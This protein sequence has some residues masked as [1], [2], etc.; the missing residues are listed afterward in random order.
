MIPTLRHVRVLLL[1]AFGLVATTSSAQSVGPVEGLNACESGDDRKALALLQPFEGRGD[2]RVDGCLAALF[3]QGIVVR[4]DTARAF[5]LASSAAAKDDA[6][7]HNVLGL[8]FKRGE[9]PNSTTP[10]PKAAFEH[11]Q[12]SADLG[13]ANGLTNLGECYWQGRGVKADALRAIAL[14]M[15]AAAKGRAVAMHHL[16]TI[17]LEGAPTVAVNR[18]QAELW[19]VRA[20]TQGKGLNDETRLEDSRDLGK[21]LLERGAVADALPYLQYA[22][23]RND[24]TA[25]ALLKKASQPSATTPVK[26]GQTGYERLDRTCV[27]QADAVRLQAALTDLY[28]GRFAPGAAKLAAAVRQAPPCLRL[29][30]LTVLAGQAKLVDKVGWTTAIATANRSYTTTN[31]SLLALAVVYFV[32]TERAGDSALGPS[33]LGPAREGEGAGMARDTLKRVK[34]V[35]GGAISQR[36]MT[37]FLEDCDT[38]EAEWH[39]LWLARRMRDLRECDEIRYPSSRPTPTA[40]YYNCVARVDA[41]HRKAPIAK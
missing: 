20:L 35:S 17:Y 23:N 37:Q 33:P 11:F 8:L 22:A 36:Q 38:T 14:L 21:L 13:F 32:G 1:I 16:A 18:E 7:A 26:T 3:Q 29:L 19:L 25:M 24:Q 10:D 4:K 12:R 39:D 28:Q 9:Q 41:Q 34:V 27:P 2:A 31:D 30:H 6:R 40:D 15:A 5:A